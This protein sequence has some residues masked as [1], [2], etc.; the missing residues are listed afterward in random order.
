MEV[1]KK[2]KKELLIALAIVFA[3]WIL[4]KFIGTIVTV[5]IIGGA[6]YFAWV[7]RELIKAK[8]KSMTS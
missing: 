1:L 3:V 4:F 7:K 6:G 8:L 5:A 2:Y